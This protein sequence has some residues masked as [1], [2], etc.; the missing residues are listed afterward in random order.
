MTEHTK[1]STG[2]DSPPPSPDKSAP[3]PARKPYSREQVL[4]KRRLVRWT[5]GICLSLIPFFIYLQGFFYRHEDSLPISNNI[6]IFGLINLNVLLVLF[7]LFLVL[8]SLAELLFERRIDR[9]GSRLKTKLIASFLSLTLIPTILLFFVALQFVSTSMDY[10]FN[11]SIEDSLQESLELAQ[12]ILHDATDQAHLMNAGIAEKLVH[13]DIDQSSTEDIRQLLTKIA[14]ESIVNR[15]YAITLIPAKSDLQISVLGPDNQNLILP[16][17]PIDTLIKAT[18]QQGSETI[19]QSTNQGDLIR[20]VSEIVMGNGKETKAILATSLL[21]KDEQLQRMEFISRGIEGY[22]QLKHFKDPFKFWI[23]IILLIVTLLIIFAAIWFGLYI[24]RGI[25]D[26]LGRLVSATQRVAEGDLEFEMESDANDEIGF[27]F[28]S[29]N[30]MTQNLNTSNKQLAETHTALQQSSQQSEQRRRYTEIILQ[31]VS[32]GVISLDDQHRITTINRFAETLLNIDKSLF[33]GKSFMEVL[34]QSQQAII[35][36]FID[37]LNSTGKTSVEQHLK[38]NVMG[39]NF[40]LLVHFNR[41]EDEEGTSLGHVLVFDNL[42]KLEKMQ[43]MA[44]WREVAKRIAHEIKNPLTPIQLSAQRLRRRYPDILAEEDRVFDECTSTIIGQ[45]DE[46]KRLVSEFSQFARMPQVQKGP[47]NLVSLARDTLILYREAHKNIAFSLRETSPVPIF[48]FDAE[49]IKRCLINL[50]DNAVAVL[51]DGGTIDIELSP[52]EPSGSI[53]IKVADNGPG[54]TKENKL[55][56]F[57]PYFSTK[58]SGT[59]LGLAIVST[60]ISDHSGYIRV[61][62]NKPRGSVFIIELPMVERQDIVG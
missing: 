51:P 28:N 36:N 49:Q 46:L 52:D 24:S 62:D 1:P 13:Y 39:R 5:I 14:R 56:L 4:Q 3:L 30:Q 15:L 59:G 18:S 55:K 47:A 20:S 48:H 42:T 29:F 32:A 44:A 53:F 50:L 43:R 40:S 12:S 10:W 17:I 61:Q 41:L 58:K 8:R 23:F 2:T 25:T 37:E 54:I 19:T 57:E 22:R 16:R 27:L 34:N 9:P 21:V 7:V 33:I 11:T 6:L 60:I 26:P 45:V 35:Q 31:N 38:L